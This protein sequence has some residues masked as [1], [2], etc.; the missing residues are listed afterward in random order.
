M[1]VRSVLGE[2]FRAARWR[3]KLAMSAAS[4]LVAGAV[5]DVVGWPRSVGQ[6][7][8]PA[9]WLGWMGCAFRSTFLSFLL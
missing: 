1:Y 5:C 9:A 7:E 8:R 3:R 2:R 6:V 4:A